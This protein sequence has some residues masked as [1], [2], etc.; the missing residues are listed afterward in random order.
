MCSIIESSFCHVG[1]VCHWCPE[2]QAWMWLPFTRSPPED[3]IWDD[4]SLFHRHLE[5]RDWI[6]TVDG[7]RTGQDLWCQEAKLMQTSPCF[8][9]WHDVESQWLL[10]DSHLRRAYRGICLI[11]IRKINFYRTL[12]VRLLT[13]I[14]LAA[15]RAHN[16]SIFI[17]GLDS[18][19]EITS[20]GAVRITDSEERRTHWKWLLI[21]RMSGCSPTTCGPIMS[22]WTNQNY[23]TGTHIRQTAA[24]CQSR[25]E[26]L[27]RCSG[28]L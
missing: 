21:H 15:S 12:Q 5:L 19:V 3:I 27:L 2:D 22:V 10:S 8:S 14:V 7:L 17:I 26:Q 24:G 1:V 4:S 6:N 16:G 18:S 9:I 23:W 11:F 20:V 28:G 13:L 25:N